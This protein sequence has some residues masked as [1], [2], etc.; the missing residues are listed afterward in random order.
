MDDHESSILREPLALNYNL[1]MHN[2]FKTF[3]IIH[4]HLLTFCR[5]DA[6]KQ[7]QNVYHS[8]QFNIR[9]DMI[10]GI[11]HPLMHSGKSILMIGINL[12]FLLSR[13]VNFLS[14]FPKNV[15]KISKY[16]TYYIKIHG[17]W[18]QNANLINISGIFA[19]SNAFL[20]LLSTLSKK[21]WRTNDHFHL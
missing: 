19:K 16:S 18:I 1:H 7:K 20:G 21:E 5:S 10:N 6:N 12:R 11:F 17:Y 13:I 14:R 9:T 3:F 4:A 8:D 2:S 15:D